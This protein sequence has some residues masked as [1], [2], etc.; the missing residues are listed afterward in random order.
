MTQLTLFQDTLYAFRVKVPGG[1][2]TCACQCAARRFG[3]E[4]TVEAWPRPEWYDT[5]QCGCMS[6][7]SLTHRVTPTPPCE[8]QTQ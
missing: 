8:I 6:G 3:G 4:A 7:F 1:S 5:P 2:V